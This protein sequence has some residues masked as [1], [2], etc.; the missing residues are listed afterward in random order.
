MKCG[1]KS[2]K[3]AATLKRCEFDLTII[4]LRRNC[5]TLREREESDDDDLRDFGWRMSV[6]SAR[7][8]SYHE[9][10]ERAETGED[11]GGRRLGEVRSIGH[12]M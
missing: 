10:E 2:N 9:P 5:E 4:L 8:E 11:R 12:V 6:A 7:T 1:E 3:P